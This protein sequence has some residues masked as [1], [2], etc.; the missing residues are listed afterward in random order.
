M[1]G[2]QLIRTNRDFYVPKR[3]VKDEK[4]NG[5]A[6]GSSFPSPLRSPRFARALSPFPFPFWSLLRRPNIPMTANRKQNAVKLTSRK[7]DTQVM[8]RVVTKYGKECLYKVVT[9]NAVIGVN[10]AD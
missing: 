8:V 7:L 2:I 5:A 3:D 9:K 10:E 4:D 6:A 1:I